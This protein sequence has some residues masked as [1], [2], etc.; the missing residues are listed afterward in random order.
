VVAKRRVEAAEA[1]EAV[2]VHEALGG[3]DRVVGR[4]AVAL[5]EQEEVAIGVVGRERVDVQDAVVQGPEHVERRLRAPIV[6]LVAREQGQQ[7]REFVMAQVRRR[8]HGRTVEPQLRFKSS[9]CLDN[10]P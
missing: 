9:Q 10:S 7:R 4:G 3:Q 2:N 8:Q 1:G 5:G 6:L